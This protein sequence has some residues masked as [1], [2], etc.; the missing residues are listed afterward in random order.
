MTIDKA[1]IGGFVLGALIL[2]LSFYDLRSRFIA[3]TSSQNENI[4]TETAA[5]ASPDAANAGEEN[6]AAHVPS[7]SPVHS[8]KPSSTPVAIKPSPSPTPSPSPIADYYPSGFHIGG[9]QTDGTTFEETSSLP[10][11][12]VGVMFTNDARTAG[13]GI[14]KV[15]VYYDNNYKTELTHA[16]YGAWGF[17]FDYYPPIEGGS[18]SV[19]FVMNEDH[20]M[21]ESNYNNNERTLHYTINAEKIPPTFTIDGPYAVS[22]QTCMRIINL[23]DNVSVYTDVWYK[24]KIDD[25]IW[26]ERRSGT[27]YGCITAAPNTQHTYYIHAE[28]RN[29]NVK[30]DSRLFSAF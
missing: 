14:V 17:T 2:G 12:A 20:A 24:W 21:L 25:G 7:P 18:H 5:S 27:E 11:F 23:E 3:A 1:Y 10:A 13:T 30:E 22:G 28:D 26:S 8:A 19:R 16:V 9:S 6:N 15:R 29:G 4:K